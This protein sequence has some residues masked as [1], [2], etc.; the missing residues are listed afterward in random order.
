MPLI[1]LS[2]KEFLES[3][4]LAK[5]SWD[6]ESRTEDFKSVSDPSVVPVPWPRVKHWR[7][8]RTYPIT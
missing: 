6:S 8:F 7:L 5:I 1:I 4:I 3:E 2:E